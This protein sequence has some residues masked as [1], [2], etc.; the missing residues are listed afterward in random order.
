MKNEVQRKEESYCLSKA[1]INF[2]SICML[3]SFFSK[4]EN[5]H[6]SSVDSDEHSI[7]FNF[8]K[9]NEDVSSVS[10]NSPLIFR[11]H[12]SSTISFYLPTLHLDYLFV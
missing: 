4:H 10:T 11:F 3:L 8:L 6:I 7:N 12:P 9:G 5:R 2:L 1:T